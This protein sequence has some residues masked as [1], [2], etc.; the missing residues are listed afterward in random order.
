VEPIPNYLFL[1]ARADAKALTASTPEDVDAWRTIARAYR[2]IARTRDIVEASRERIIEEAL[3][4]PDLKPQTGM[5][6]AHNSLD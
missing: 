3:K 4:Y 6:P 1:A 2:L 5:H